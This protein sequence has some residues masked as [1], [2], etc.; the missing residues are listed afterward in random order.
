MP[1]ASVGPSRSHTVSTRWEELRNSE[2]LRGHW[3]ALDR[4]RY[5]DNRQPVEGEVVDS[6]EDL[7]ELCARMK[8][9]DRTSCA[10]LFCEP[11][12]MPAASVRRPTFR[13]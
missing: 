3:V 8:A 4:V 13:H 2:E 7:G 11:E 9:N 6:D 10:I 1:R 12:E 5:D